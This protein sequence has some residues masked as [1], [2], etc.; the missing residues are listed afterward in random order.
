MTNGMYEPHIKWTDSHLFKQAK[1]LSHTSSGKTLFL[2]LFLFL[3]TSIAAENSQLSR[4]ISASFTFCTQNI[5]MAAY[6]PSVINL[7][8]MVHAM[9]HGPFGHH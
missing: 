6:L 3:Q 8:Q 5:K 2:F 4:D 7:Q 9:H 1:Q